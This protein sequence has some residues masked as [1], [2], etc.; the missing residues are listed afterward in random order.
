[1]AGGESSIVPNLFFSG[2]RRILLMMKSIGSLLPA[3]SERGPTRADGPSQSSIDDRKIQRDRGKT[4][5]SLV[6]AGRRSGRGDIAARAI[7]G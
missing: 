1:M 5:S 7:S 3:R 6:I 4:G 2:D